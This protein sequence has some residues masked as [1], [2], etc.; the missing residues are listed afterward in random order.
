MYIS[1]TNRVSTEKGKNNK[2]EKR[3]M[4]WG[5]ALLPHLCVEKFVLPQIQ[6]HPRVVVVSHGPQVSPPRPPPPPLP[7]SVFHAVPSD[8]I[9]LPP[10]VLSSPLLSFISP[11]SFAL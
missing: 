5:A 7:F 2:I 9:V 8:R 4:E 1:K 11:F 6:N 3:R 10:I